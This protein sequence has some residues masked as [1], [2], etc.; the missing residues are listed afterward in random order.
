MQTSELGDEECINFRPSPNFKHMKKYLKSKFEEANSSPNQGSDRSTTPNSEEQDSVKPQQVTSS[1][2]MA[3]RVQPPLPPNSPPPDLV[4]P[5][6]EVEDDEYIDGTATQSQLKTEKEE[7]IEKAPERTMCRQFARG[8]C[9][10]GASCIY[11]H[12]LI[13]SQL[14]G[15]YTFCKNYQNTVCNFPK[16][17]FVHASIAGIFARADSLKKVR[18]AACLSE[19]RVL[20]YVSAIC[21]KPCSSSFENCSSVWSSNTVYI[22][23]IAGIFARADSLK[24]VRSAACL[25]EARVL[26]Y[27]SA[28]CDKPCSSSFENCSSVWSNSRYLRSCGLAEEGEERRVSVRSSGALVRFRHLRQALLVLLRELQ[29]RVV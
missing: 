15:V 6:Q 19:A 11:V 12:E 25:S 23:Q 22:Y 27:V 2:S 29:Q 9:T 10:R 28:I 4:V 24:K 7:V 14:P 13:L 1:S 20:L 16:C 21:D 5:K 17:K 18:S 8:M 3:Q 26:L